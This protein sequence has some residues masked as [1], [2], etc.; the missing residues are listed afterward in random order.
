MNTYKVRGLYTISFEMEVEANSREEAEEM[1]YNIDIET[2]WDGSYAMAEIP[3]EAPFAVVVVEKDN[4]G[5]YLAVGAA[6][7]VLLLVISGVIVH[8]KR[9]RNVK[10]K[11]DDIK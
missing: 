10:I 6:T 11:R 4:L 7:L 5:S 2:E 1:G 8:N 9:K 3:F